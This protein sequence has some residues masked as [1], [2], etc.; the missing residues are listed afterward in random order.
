MINIRNNHENRT[1]AAAD[2]VVAVLIGLQ[3]GAI[4]VLSSEHGSAL[5]S[6]ELG[7]ILFIHKVQ[8]DV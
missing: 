1:T 2:T 6:F 4:F 3:Y 5:A 8:E 7:Q